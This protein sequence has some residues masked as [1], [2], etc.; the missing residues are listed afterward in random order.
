MI[1]AEKKSHKILSLHL[2]L[3]LMIYEIKN[4]PK[5]F[6]QKVTQPK[7]DA[8]LRIFFEPKM[9]QF[10]TLFLHYLRIITTA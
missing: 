5:K 8:F 6:V 10:F 1:L 2:P 7:S 3:K 9:R 4:F